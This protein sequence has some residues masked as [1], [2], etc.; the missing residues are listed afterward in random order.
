MIQGNFFR[1]KSNL[2]EISPYKTIVLQR[3]HQVID[4]KQRVSLNN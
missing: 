4:E 2:F 1:E 3:E